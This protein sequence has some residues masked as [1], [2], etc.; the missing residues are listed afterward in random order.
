MPVDSGLQPLS[1]ANAPSPIDHDRRMT[2]W[3]E[4]AKG[5]NQLSMAALVL[6]VFFLRTVLGIPPDQALVAHIDLA[7]WISWGFLSVSIALGLAYQLIATKLLTTGGS[8]EMPLYPERV[9]QGT[10]ASMYVGLCA[11]VVGVIV[12]RG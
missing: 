8:F 10:V 9:F 4:A 11:F 2:L 1:Q 3:M 5:C 12:H 6:P 7:L